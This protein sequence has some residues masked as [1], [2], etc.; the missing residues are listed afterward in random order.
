MIKRS[1]LVAQPQL[2]L[3]VFQRVEETGAAV[4][5]SL[6]LSRLL[7]KG[8]AGPNQRFQLVLVYMPQMQTDK[9]IRLHYI[10]H[11]CSEHH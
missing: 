10:R 2:F 8:L 7:L 1:H 9:H 11:T 5:Q 4:P 3:S 6:H